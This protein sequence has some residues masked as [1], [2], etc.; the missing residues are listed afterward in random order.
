MTRIRR[1]VYIRGTRAALEAFEV[2]EFGVDPETGDI[3]RPVEC[4]RPSGAFMP[5]MLTSEVEVDGT[6]E[7][8]Y[9]PE[10][11]SP[12][13]IVYATVFGERGDEVLANLSAIAG[14][15]I[16]EKGVD[17]DHHEELRAVWPLHFPGNVVIHHS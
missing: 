17:F 7:T 1:R 15:E 11:A 3:L 6:T 5:Q 13:L 16:L 4:W 2:A 12:D 10:P 9:T 14:V 8:V